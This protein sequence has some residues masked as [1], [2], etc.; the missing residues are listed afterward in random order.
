[1][2]FRLAT[3]AAAQSLKAV[4]TRRTIAQI[5]QVAGARLFTTTRVASNEYT[6]RLS[7]TLKD[8]LTHEKQNDTE[9]PVELNSFIA[10]SGFEVVN[11]DGQA[12]AKLQKNGTDEVVHVFF[13]VNQV[14][15]VRPAVEEVE[16]EEEEEFEDPYENFI[17]LNVVVEKKA[18]DSAVAFDVL[19]GP[20]DGST[21]IENVIAYANKAEALTETADADQKRELAYNGPAFS[22]LD[23][24]LQENFEQFLTS[25]GINEELYQFILNYGIHKENQEYIAWLEKLNKFFK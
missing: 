20:E 11:T 25:R 21:Y 19:V 2:S 12:L 3:R 23:E 1:M 17:N 15:N 5:P 18:D 4:A 16:V 24:K 9:V 7:E 22:N 10:Q 6:S 8:E 14:V 13:D